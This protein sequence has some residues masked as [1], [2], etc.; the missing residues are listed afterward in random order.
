[1][2][3]LEIITKAAV[4]SENLSVQAKY[5]IIL[6]SDE[7]LSNLEPENEETDDTFL[8]KRVGGWKI[9][10]TDT[11]IIELGNKFSKKLKRKLKNPKSFGVDE[12]LEVLNSFLVKTTKKI[13][14]SVEVDQSDPGYTRLMIEKLG[15]FIA[16]DVVGLILE[17]CVVLELW[18]LVETLIIHGVVGN[19][20]STNLIESLVKKKRSDLLCLCIKYISDLKSSD[21]VCLFM[22]FLSPPKGAYSTMI[23]VRKDWENQ[24][25]LAI[26][27]ASN[28]NPSTKKSSLAK[29]ASIL[30]MVAYDGFSPSELCLHYLFASSNLD[31]MTLS[32]SLSRL[33]GS[34]M[35]SLIRYLGKWVSK[36]EK[37]PQAGPCPKAAS[38]LGLK[39]CEWVPSLESVV[40]HL[41]LIV[42]EHFSSLVLYSEFH[43]ELRLIDGVVKSLASEA[44]LCCSVADLVENLKSEVEIRKGA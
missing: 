31:Q 16:R 43:D 44:R 5:P 18:E 9:S 12:F 6:N 35:L 24:A 40:K 41:G 39:A 20:S 4:D 14:L 32:Y 22:Y 2:S 25:I 3:L 15:F 34:E 21:L 27:K 28:Q 1:M 11:K 38:T 23:N 19:L 26:E 8:I 30:L 10:E 36:Y 33:N 37:F 17:T 7:I 42:D 29:Q 13:G